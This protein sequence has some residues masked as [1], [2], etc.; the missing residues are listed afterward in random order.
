MV[1]LLISHTFPLAPTGLHRPPIGKWVKSAFGRRFDPFTVRIRR[2]EYV[3]F[4]IK[5]RIDPFYPKVVLTQYFFWKKI[6]D[7]LGF[8]W[9]KIFCPIL[10]LGSRLSPQIDPSEHEFGVKIF[11]RRSLEIA[12]IDT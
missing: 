2:L 10:V 4:A 1:I 12:A 11:F 5:S 3:K 8:F 9:V 7:S 6:P